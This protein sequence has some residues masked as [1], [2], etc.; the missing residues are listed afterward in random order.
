MKITLKLLCVLVCL[1]L[2]K[3]SRLNVMLYLWVPVPPFC[4]KQNPCGSLAEQLS[5]SREAI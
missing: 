3:M 1:I 5:I 2:D 4:D